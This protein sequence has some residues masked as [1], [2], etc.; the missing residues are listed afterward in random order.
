MATRKPPVKRRRQMTHRQSTADLSSR[1]A[2]LEAVILQIRRD[3][4]TQFHRMAQLQAELDRARRAP[5]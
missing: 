1:V 2:R 5:L 4:R 3:L